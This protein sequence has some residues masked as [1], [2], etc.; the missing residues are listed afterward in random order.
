MD[1]KEQVRSSANIVHVIG[2]YVRLKRTGA[3]RWVGLC[4]F[5]G[6]KSPSFSVSEDK[7]FYHC[8][9]CKASGDVFKFLQEIEGVSFFEALKSLAE[10]YGI[11][12][13]KRRDLTDEQTEQRTA[14]FRMYEIAGAHYQ[15][16]LRSP[17]GAE[18]LAYIRKRGLTDETLERFGVGY[19]ERG[20]TAL[21]RKLREAGFADPLIEASRLCLKRESGG[22]YDFFRHRVM[23]PIHNESGKLIAFGGRAL[24]S[25]EPKY[26][27]STDTPIYTKKQVLYNLNRARQA[28]RQ[29]EEVVLVE[30]YMDTIGLAQAGIAH[31][32]APCGTALSVEQTK[33]LKRHTDRVIVNFDPDNAGATATERSIQLLLDEA[34]HIRVLTLDDGL[35]PDEFV[36][37]HGAEGYRRRLSSADGYFHWLA[38][39]ARTRF[40]MRTAESRIEG[41]RKLLEPAILRIPDRMERLAV[42]N[43]IAAYLGVDADVIRERFRKQDA[44]TRK[45]RPNDRGAGLMRKVTDSERSLLRAAFGDGEM[46]DAL[47]PVLH[48][49]PMFATLET[50]RIF[51]AIAAIV[52]SRAPF[53]FTEVE[54]RLEENDRA[55]LAALVLADKNSERQVDQA[56]TPEQARACLDALDQMW[57]KDRLAE[58][59]QQIKAAERR[60]DW[61]TAFALMAERQKVERERWRWSGASRSER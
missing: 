37:A 7:Q 27:N 42:A 11:T 26:L 32:V 29:T 8:F 51:G 55:L 34:F 4:P 14:V 9:G 24:G 18:A 20:G 59:D 2:E 56:V 44:V 36:A 31:V 25:D 40:D 5:H 12:I 41:F 54:A 28:I 3:G 57:R 15:N 61:E 10:R 53:G 47:V 43:E 48:E 17:A 50:R 30:G 52:E 22:Y 39:R 13:P 58:T 23:F 33:M 49:H 1:F 60:G 19:A 45:P 38:N 35:D 46:R 16:E 21:Y 6:E